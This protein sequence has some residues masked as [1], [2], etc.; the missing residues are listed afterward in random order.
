MAC[1][2]TLNLFGETVTSRV[3]LISESGETLDP[4]E[5]FAN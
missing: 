2:I 3:N 5:G 1:D 4:I